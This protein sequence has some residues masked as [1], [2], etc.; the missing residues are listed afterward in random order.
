M[1]AIYRGENAY[2]RSIVGALRQTGT[3][4]NVTELAATLSK[5]AAVGRVVLETLEQAGDLQEKTP[6]L[7]DGTVNESFICPYWAG[8][9]LGEVDRIRRDRFVNAYDSFTKGPLRAQQHV[10]IL[11]SVVQSLRAAGRIPVLMEQAMGDHLSD[12][13]PEDLMQGSLSDTQELAERRTGELK[14]RH[15]DQDRIRLQRERYE[16]SA[17]V[18]AMLSAQLGIDH[19]I[20][21]DA[22][23]PRQITQDALRGINVKNALTKAIE[24]LGLAPDKVT[25][26]ID[27]HIYEIRPTEALIPMTGLSRVEIIPI[28]TCCLGKTKSTLTEGDEGWKIRNID[29]SEEEQRQ[30]AEAQTNAVRSIVTDLRQRLERLKVS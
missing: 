12:M 11:R 19:I 18:T 27:H 1:P 16:K 4:V 10:G 17:Q 23:D 13:K 3:S 15:P 14:R 7:V 21:V 29:L 5:D 6:V 30:L 26:L 20:G 28:C 9:Q 22:F 2:M 25:L 24:A 8:K